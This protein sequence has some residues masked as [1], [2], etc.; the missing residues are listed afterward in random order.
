MLDIVY[1]FYVGLNGRD[2]QLMKE[3]KQSILKLRGMLP[4]STCMYMYMCMCMCNM[5]PGATEIN[6]KECVWGNHQVNVY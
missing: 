3:C 1:D 2:I 5:L 6:G 4:P